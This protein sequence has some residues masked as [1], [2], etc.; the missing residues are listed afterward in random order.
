[1]SEVSVIEDDHGAA[2]TKV[3]KRRRVGHLSTRWVGLT[4]TLRG[5]E[6]GGDRYRSVGGVHQVPLGG[7]SGALILAGLDAVGPDAPGLLEHVGADVIVCLQTADEIDMRFPA[8]LDWLK[9]PEPHE[10][11]RAPIEDHLVIDD[12]DMATLVRAVVR[13]LSRGESLVVHCGAGWGRAG[14]VAALVLVAFGSG[15]DD[16]LTR[17]RSARPA[18]GPQ[19]PEQHAQLERLTPVL[20]G[21]RSVSADEAAQRQAG[22][23]RGTTRRNA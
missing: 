10:V 23:R 12:R 1:V 15:L 9:H 16:A 11:V 13:R 21:E 3:A 6:I 20:H 22:D 17:V 5:V 2:M 4:A 18:A 14:L 8:Y 19:S 7:V